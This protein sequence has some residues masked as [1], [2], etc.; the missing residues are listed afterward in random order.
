MVADLKK[1]QEDEVKTKAYCVKEFHLNEKN[2]Y[3]KTEEKEDLE[4]K[5]ELLAST[6]E[7][8]TSDIQAAQKQIADANLEIKKA[9]EAREK[10]N[11][12]FQT[13][14]ADQRA[15]QSILAKALWRLEVFYKT[16]D[17]K[18][19]SLLQT[20][21]LTEEAQSPPVK[22]S[23]YKKNAGSVSVISLLEQIVEDSKALESEAMAGE[24]KAQANYETFV[25]GSNKVIA[26]LEAEVSEKTKLVASAQVDTEEAKSDHA[27][28]V[29]VIEFLEK[30][31]AYLHKECDYLLKNFDLR[32][33][34]RLEEIEA[35]QQAKAI[36]SGSS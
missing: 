36:L 30:S 14:V 9:S 11:A 1:E 22:F 25:K 16:K 21:A 2:T 29:A 26:S 20:S 31:L 15:T 18:D 10:A 13:I 27:S 32:Q 6:I 12:E 23:A 4:A 17:S 33:K 8:L 5:L 28:A 35:I 24:R 34:A 3:H 19:T 7:Q